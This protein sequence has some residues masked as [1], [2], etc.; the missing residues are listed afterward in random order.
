MFPEFAYTF[1][2]QVIHAANALTT[3]TLMMYFFANLLLKVF[4]EE[5]GIIQKIIFAFVTG[6]IFQTVFVFFIYFIG[7]AASFS[8]LQYSLLSTPNP[9]F[10]LLYCVMGIKVLKLSSIRS[11]KL[12]GYLYLFYLLIL[13]FFVML[14]PLLFAQKAPRYNYMLAM[15]KQ[16]ALFAFVFVIYL[17][18]LNVVKGKKHSIRISDKVFMKT[19]SELFAFFLKVSFFYILVVTLP[20]LITSK[21]VPNLLVVLILSLFLALNIYMDINAYQKAEIENK[22]IHISALSKG[23]SEFSSVKHDF[24]NILQ[25]YEGYLHVE[26]LEKLKEYHSKL[27]KLTTD[28][29]NSME[30]GK[31]MSENPALVSLLINKSD[32][33]EKTNVKMTTSI[34]CSIDTL[35]LDN[36]DICR[37]IACLLDN[38]I[39]AAAD[40][41][42]KQVFFTIENKI[43]GSKLIII[44][45][46]TIADIDINEI[47]VK[48]FTSKHNHS[49][50]GLSNVHRII[51]S[52]GNCTFQISYYN[53]E[54]SA[55][56]ELRKN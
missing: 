18:A 52:H 12:M 35:Y 4:D 42:Q 50:M 14:S 20:L 16:I 24:Y 10:A 25:T 36:L 41:E 48:G 26:N 39:E 7:G 5:T 53:Y 37:C 21:F 34:Q 22:E 40:S 6:G 33:A 47:I 45:N 49:G 44:T 46:S 13:E 28:A 27:L 17:I 32:H 2:M 29:G 9:L 31:K 56:L 3:N 38:A 8:P 23:I 15:F 54:F 51:E 55:Y 19:S 11:I 1:G 43:G 30:L